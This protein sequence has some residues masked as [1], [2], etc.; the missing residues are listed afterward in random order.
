MI[1]VGEKD[2]LLSSDD[3]NMCVSQ[4]RW[5]YIDGVGV[6]ITCLFDVKGPPAS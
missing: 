1:A 5:S 3:G 2:L 6:C 4:R